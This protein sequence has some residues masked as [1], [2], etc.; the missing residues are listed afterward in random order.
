[1]A[2]NIVE[3]ERGQPI[4]CAGVVLR[5]AVWYP[6]LRGCSPSSLFSL[7]CANCSLLSS[8]THFNRTSNTFRIVCT[9]PRSMLLQG[10]QTYKPRK[11]ETTKAFVMIAEW[12][13]KM[14]YGKIIS[15]DYPASKAF[16][17]Q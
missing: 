11:E 4:D 13:E 12:R 10:Y 16:H 14:V 1:M 2:M 6:R 17:E 7:L 9:V 3:S 5:G 15:Q 8:D